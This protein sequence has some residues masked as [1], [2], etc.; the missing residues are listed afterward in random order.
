MM[1]MQMRFFFTIIEANCL[2]HH[3]QI[4]GALSSLR[5]VA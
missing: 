1:M 3:A 4:N 2:T 5:E